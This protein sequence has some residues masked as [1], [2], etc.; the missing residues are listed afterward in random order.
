M[1]FLSSAIELYIKGNHTSSKP[2]LQI[3]EQQSQLRHLIPEQ[4]D[5]QKHLLWKTQDTLGDLH[6]LRAEDFQDCASDN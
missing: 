5:T 1:H 4:I 2:Q 3:L 6:S